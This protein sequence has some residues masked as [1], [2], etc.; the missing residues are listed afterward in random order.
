M[1]G[2]FAIECDS[3]C[4][5]KIEIE[6]GYKGILF[7]LEGQNSMQCKALSGHIDLVWQKPDIALQLLNLRSF[8]LAA[9]MIRLFSNAS[10]VE[11]GDKKTLLLTIQHRTPTH[12]IPDPILLFETEHFC[13]SKL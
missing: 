12:T 11:E 5:S 3:I 13:L 6:N 8:Y 4:I 9:E 10:G 2:H 1:S 7:A